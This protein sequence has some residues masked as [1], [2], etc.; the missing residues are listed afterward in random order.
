MP[1]VTNEP[2]LYPDNLFDIRVAEAPWQIAYVKSRCEKALARHLSDYGVPFYLPLHDKKLRHGEKERLSRVPLFP[3]YLFYRGGR[4]ARLAA[5]R[6]QKLVRSIAVE[7]QARLNEELSR[8]RQLQQEGFLLIPHPY[9][10]VGDPVEIREGAFRGYR[11]IVVRERETERLVVSITLLRQSVAVEIDRASL[12]PLSTKH[13]D[14]RS[15]P[16]KAA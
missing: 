11:G 1:L 15:T 6:S 13:E 9:L 8:L 7:D 14:L 3:G 12:R 16:S 10:S 2:D 5:L 4:E